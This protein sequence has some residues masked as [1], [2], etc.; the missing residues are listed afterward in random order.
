[1]FLAA[2][3]LSLWLAG[4]LVE[5]LELSSCGVWAYLPHGMW[6]LCSPTRDRTRIPCIGR[7]ILCH[8]TTRE[9]LGI[10]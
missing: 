4:S 3:G 6:D 2:S 10:F 8:W 7:W 9:V 5:V 1:M